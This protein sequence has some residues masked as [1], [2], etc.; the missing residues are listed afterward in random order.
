MTKQSGVSLDREVVPSGAAAFWVSPKTG[1]H[2]WKT[3]AR[4]D[5]G[6]RSLD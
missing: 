6:F 3:T 1:G 2:T 4:L 5:V